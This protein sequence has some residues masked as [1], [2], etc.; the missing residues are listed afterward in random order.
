MPKA[1]ALPSAK[2]SVV[3]TAIRQAA[4]FREGLRSFENI[5]D[6]PNRLDERFSAVP[7]DFAAQA[8]DVHVDDVRRGID[9]HAPDMIENHRSSHNAALVSTE[10]FQKYEFLRREL[11]R[12]IAFPRFTADQIELKI[13]DL[14]L[15]RLLLRS[16]ASLEKVSKAGQKLGKSEGLRE[17]IVAALLEA[18]DPFVDGPPGGQDQYGGVAALSAAIGDEVEAITVGK[19]EVDDE[20]VVVTLARQRLRGFRIRSRIDL[21]TGLGERPAQEF[22]DRDVVFNQQ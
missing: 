5:S 20:R 10:V 19:S 13:G 12:L 3:Q 14:Q 8:I 2:A 21:I 16:A 18:P 22:P 4:V 1:S 9:S 15:E 11:K 6:S 7:V 17:V